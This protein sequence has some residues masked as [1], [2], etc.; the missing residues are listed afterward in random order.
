MNLLCIV[1]ISSAS[2]SPSSP[3]SST[4]DFNRSMLPQRSLFGSNNQTT[5]PPHHNYSNVPPMSHNATASGPPTQVKT[6][7][8][9]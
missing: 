6:I 3:V 4:A 1:S 2:A 9:V 8:T 7:L 5:S